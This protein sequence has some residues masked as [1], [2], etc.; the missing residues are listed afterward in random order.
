MHETVFT[1]T[2]PTPPN[3]K[4]L[5]LRGHRRF[6]GDANQ[7]RLFVGPKDV[8]LLKSIDPKLEQLVDFGWMSV[9]AKPL[10]LIVNWANDSIVHNFGWSIILVT[11]VINFALFPLQT[12]QHEVDAQDAG[13]QA[14]D[15]RHQRQVQGH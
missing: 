11:I 6:D 1:D 4:S 3:A 13:A 14:A 8:D 9:L 2:V 5:A 7:F 10:F 15:R 12:L